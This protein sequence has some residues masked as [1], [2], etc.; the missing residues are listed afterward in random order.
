MWKNILLTREVE[1]PAGEE[2]SEGSAANGGAPLGPRH[3]G[4]RRA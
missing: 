4:D 1:V 3:F 2:L